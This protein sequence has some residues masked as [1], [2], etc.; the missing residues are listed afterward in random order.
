MYQI[1][2]PRKKY[3]IWDFRDNRYV[4]EFDTLD[5]LIY[6]IAQGYWETHELDWRTLESVST[7]VN[8]FI[9]RCACSANE[10]NG[11]R[12]FI[13]DSYGRIINIHSLEDRA[14]AIYQKKMNEGGFDWMTHHTFY[15]KL[16]GYS[17]YYFNRKHRKVKKINYPEFRRGP[18]PYTGKHGGGPWQSGPHTFQIKKM[19]VNPEF[20][21]YNRGSVKEVPSWWDDRDRCRQRSWKAQSKK[22]HQWE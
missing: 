5:E 16:R 11:R 9:D 15:M 8:S 4:D 3:Y 1:I 2:P 12:Y 22:R 13:F 10:G 21:G 17:N 6:F 14:F 18:V 7:I 20:K 19:Y